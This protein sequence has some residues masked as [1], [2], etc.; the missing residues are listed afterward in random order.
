LDQNNKNSFD[1]SYGN[2]ER[3]KIK[4]KT[5]LITIELKESLTTLDVEISPMMSAT[6]PLETIIV[7]VT[8]HPSSEPPIS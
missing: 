5:T 1:V 6:K 4:E 7:P 2:Y 8:A 3:Q